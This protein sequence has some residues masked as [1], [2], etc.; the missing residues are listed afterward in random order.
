MQQCQ[1][2]NKNNNA[3]ALILIW[4]QDINKS[5]T[6]REAVTDKDY[7]FNRPHLTQ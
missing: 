2:N 1:K 7:N 4:S 6:M 3:K 5:K